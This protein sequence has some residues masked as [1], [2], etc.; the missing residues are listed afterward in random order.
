MRQYRNPRPLCVSSRRFRCEKNRG[1]SSVSVDLGFL[2]DQRSVSIPSD[3][4]F[5][6]VRQRLHI[7][8]GEQHDRLCGSDH[9]FSIFVFAAV[10]IES[11]E[12]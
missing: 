6:S 5:P 1:L 3:L 8:E 4:A 12:V 2:H 9:G 10:N 7:C 11:K